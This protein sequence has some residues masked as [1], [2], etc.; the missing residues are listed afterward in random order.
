[1]RLL[2]IPGKKLMDTARP[3]SMQVEQFQFLG[4]STVLGTE[5]KHIPWTLREKPFLGKIPLR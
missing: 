1:M 2:Q 4:R 5:R 3:N